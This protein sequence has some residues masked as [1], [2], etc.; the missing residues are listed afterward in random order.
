MQLI[1]QSLQ[2]CLDKIA[3]K[4]A[5]SMKSLPNIGVSAQKQKFQNT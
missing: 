4:L 5:T 1:H 2:R 3:I